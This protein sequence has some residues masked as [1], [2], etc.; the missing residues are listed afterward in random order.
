MKLIERLQEM[1]LEIE[2]IKREIIKETNLEKIKE[3]Q[4]EKYR[5]N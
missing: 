5:R 1:Y 3:K 4:N 2:L